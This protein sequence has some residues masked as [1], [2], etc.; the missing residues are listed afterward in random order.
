M[1]QKP[2][3]KRFVKEQCNTNE[4]SKPCDIYPDLYIKFIAHKPPIITF[5]N[6]PN[7]RT[8]LT[9]FTTQQIHNLLREKGLERQLSMFQTKSKLRAAPT[10]LPGQKR[11]L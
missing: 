9:E 11:G 4:S 2:E 3:V 5:N 8:D 1:N 6:N 10:F 7:D